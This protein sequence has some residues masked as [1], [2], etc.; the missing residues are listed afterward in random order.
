MKIKFSIIF[1]VACA[2]IFLCGTIC[3]AESLRSNKNMTVTKAQLAQKKSCAGIK[4]NK[5]LLKDQI[6]KECLKNLKKV[7]NLSG[8]WKTSFADLSLLQT[9]N[10]VTGTYAYKGGKLEGTITGNRFE[11]SW[12]QEDGKKGKGYFIVTN[13]GQDIDGKYG[14]DDNSTSGG[15]W[16]GK[17]ISLPGCE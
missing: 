17:K 9:G 11:Y 10:K 1:T 2:F 14:Y 6:K 8:L 7:E 12:F 13:N 5:G 16:S 15:G 3:F 4:E